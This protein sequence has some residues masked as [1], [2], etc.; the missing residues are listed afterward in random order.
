M[1]LANIKMILEI[2][3]VILEIVAL[4]RKYFLKPKKK[5]KHRSSGRK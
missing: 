1:V 4:V 5:K 3:L 2:I